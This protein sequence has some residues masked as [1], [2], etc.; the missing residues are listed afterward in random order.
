LHFWENTNWLKNKNKVLLWFW[1]LIYPFISYFVC[2]ILYDWGIFFPFYPLFSFLKISV[3]FCWLTSYNSWCRC[4][5]SFYMLFWNF[6]LMLL[7]SCCSYFHVKISRLM[8]PPLFATLPF[9]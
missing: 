6:A 4:C 5:F 3:L 2:I 1:W 9:I 8:H 7:L